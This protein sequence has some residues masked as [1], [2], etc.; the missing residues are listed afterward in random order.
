MVKKEE[1]VV[2]GRTKELDV[3]PPKFREAFSHVVVQS[4]PDS[5]LKPKETFPQMP[6]TPRFH[7]IKYEEVMK[8]KERRKALREKIKFFKKSKELKEKEK[9]E[10]EVKEKPEKTKKKV[11]VRK[12]GP[13]SSVNKKKVWGVIIFLL[14]VAVVLAVVYFLG[15]EK[16]PS[17]QELLVGEGIDYAYVQEDVI[18]LRLLPVDFSDVDEMEFI[19]TDDQGNNYVYSTYYLESDHEFYPD[20]FNLE[21]LNNVE[22]IA[23]SFN[24]KSPSP[25]LVPEVN[26]TIPINATT[27]NQTPTISGGGSP[28]PVL[29]C[30]DDSGCSSVGDFCDGQMSYSCSLGVDGCFD[31]TNKTFCGG[32]QV[33]LN[34]ECQIIIDCVSDFDCVSYFDSCSYGVCNASGKCEVRYNST[35]DVCRESGGECDVV[36]F[37]DGFSGE[38]PVNV[39]KTGGSCTVGGFE[40]VC[41]YGVCVISGNCGDGVCDFEEDCLS[42]AGDCVCED[43][44]PYCSSGTCVE[45]LEDNHCDSGEVCSSNSCVLQ[46][47]SCDDGIL[48]SGEVCDGGDLGGKTCGD[49]FIYG[50]GDLGCCESCD[51]F[52]LSDCKNYTYTFCTDFD[53]GI[54]TDFV[55]SV[56]VSFDWN[57]GPNCTNN[58]S[59]LFGAGGR[60]YADVCEGDVLVEYYCGSDNAPMTARYNCSS[61]DKVCQYGACHKPIFP[62]AS[63]WEGIKELI[64]R[65]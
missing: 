65:F 3:G 9:K 36:E 8:E 34:G 42:C 53:G 55:S 32:G 50:E 24:Y 22:A 54:N 10:Q 46:V 57:N 63:F 52:D 19:L 30:T 48:D 61:E 2:V 11:V 12:K 18:Y 17:T 15:L 49:F 59:T 23:V 26:E 28:G 40:G 21:S 31:R 13:D 27:A 1:K 5:L 4:N 38:C 20:N 35:V 62:T 58:K 41:E 44:V 51:R 33:C 56:S 45:C 60:S 14:V 6:K 64:R 43:P 39:N 7:P 29:S 37:C 47:S 16:G 25:V